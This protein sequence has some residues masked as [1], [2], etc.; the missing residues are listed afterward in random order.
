M[1]G[2]PDAESI[3][4]DGPDPGLAEL[5]ANTPKEKLEE[6]FKAHRRTAAVRYVP[7]ARVP[8]LFQF[9]RHERLFNLAPM[10]RYVGPRPAR[11]RSSGTIRGTT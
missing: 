10:E 2:V 3:Y 7:H 11:S 9:A 1:G 6:F 4:R 8:L 5:R